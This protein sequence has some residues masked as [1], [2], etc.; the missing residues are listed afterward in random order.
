MARTRGLCEAH[1]KRA[2][3]HKCGLNPERPIGGYIKK[4]KINKIFIKGIQDSVV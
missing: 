3:Y 1:Y 4:R 2:K